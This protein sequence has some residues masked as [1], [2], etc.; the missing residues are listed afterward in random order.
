M[1][2][3]TPLTGSRLRIV[4]VGFH[5]LRALLEELAPVYSPLAEIIILDK[6]YSQAVER[7]GAM[8]Q[9]GGV[10][11]VVSSGTNGRSEENTSELQSLMRITYAVFCLTKK[12]NIDK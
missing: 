7:I 9:S 11:A 3:F 8:R 4:A 10:D 5:G 6:A 12:I 1:A 2:L